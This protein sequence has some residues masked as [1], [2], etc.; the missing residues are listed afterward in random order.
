MVRKE[1]RSLHGQRSVEAAIIAGAPA[2]TLAG[3][4]ASALPGLLALLGA[5]VVVGLS[6]AA[7]VTITIGIL[8]LSVF[9][10]ISPIVLPEHLSV[11]EVENVK[12]I[13][14]LIVDVDGR[15]SGDKGSNKFHFLINKKT[16]T[17]AEKSKER[18]NLITDHKVMKRVKVCQ[19]I[20]YY[21][22]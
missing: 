10:I 3:S 17:K 22:K 13:L 19:L 11:V 18:P 5:E 21:L 12:L 16:K 20:K 14:I 4:G 9:S 2:T 15:S 7:I 8:G 6:E 1:T